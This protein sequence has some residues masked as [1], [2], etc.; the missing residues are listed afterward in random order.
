MTPFNPE[1]KAVLTHGE[2]LHP[3]MKITEPEDAQQYLRA[4]AAFLQAAIDRDGPRDGRTGESV[5]KFNLGYFAGYY[6]DET[7]MRVERLFCCEH[8][9]LGSAAAN[10]PTPEQALAAGI[11]AGRA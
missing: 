6:D 4:Y 1:G 7:R 10:R 8:P 9:F 11:A 5:A 2:C 3:A